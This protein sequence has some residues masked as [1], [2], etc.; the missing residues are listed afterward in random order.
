MFKRY[1]FKSTIYTLVAALLL[2]FPFAGCSLN[3]KTGETNTI[4]MG[5]IGNKINVDGTVAY[6][7]GEN[8][9]LV[10]YN[11]Y[12]DYSTCSREAS[13]K[14][15]KGCENPRLPT[16]ETDALPEEV[17]REII[18]FYGDTGGFWTSMEAA[19]ANI[20]IIG[21]EPKSLHYAGIMDNYFSVGSDNVADAVWGYCLAATNDT[22]TMGLLVLYDV[23]VGE[24]VFTDV[25]D[26]ADPNYSTEPIFDSVYEE[27]S[28]QEEQ[29]FLSHAETSSTNTNNQSSDDSSSENESNTASD[30]I[31]DNTRISLPIGKYT[32][33][34]IFSPFVG[35]VKIVDSNGNYSDKWKVEELNRIKISWGEGWPEETVENDIQRH[36]KAFE[37]IQPNMYIDVSEK[38][39][40]CYNIY[41][42]FD[43]CKGII[44]EMRVHETDDE[45]YGHWIGGYSSIDSSMGKWYPL[46]AEIYEVREDGSAYFTYW[47]Y[48]F[49]YYPDIKGIGVSIDAGDSNYEVLFTLQ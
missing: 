20:E 42:D 33:S 24:F 35:W 34:H 41:N 37:R 28:S 31:D 12:G 6:V 3:D 29:I 14:N 39:M 4:D 26:T 16:D 27:N 11:F 46:D 2:A 7:A 10:P 38:W 22:T 5:T 32:P 17:T 21:A 18:S 1:G 25:E 15:L 44:D 23:I 45:Y 47:G 19:R 30:D 48:D 36:S 13:D 49:L 9:I 40:R 8:K 43:L